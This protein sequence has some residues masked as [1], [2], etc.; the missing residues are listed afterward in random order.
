MRGT[1][2]SSRHKKRM[3]LEIHHTTNDIDIYQ[4]LFLVWWAFLQ[5]SLS[6]TDYRY[7]IL[8]AILVKPLA[9]CAFKHLPIT[10]NL[11]T[12]YFPRCGQELSPPP[13]PPI[14]RAH[15][16]KEHYNTSRLKAGIKSHFKPNRNLLLPWLSFSVIFL[17]C[18][19]NA[20]VEL[21]RRGPPALFSN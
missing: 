14:S 1:G 21:V 17:S 6:R 8:I 18:K 20:R 11:K 15:F 12:V 10:P 3:S 4:V 19:A 2:K 5:E 9:Q 16:F 13:P 7:D